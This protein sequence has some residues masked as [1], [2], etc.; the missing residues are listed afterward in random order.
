MTGIPVFVAFLVISVTGVLVVAGPQGFPMVVNSIFDT[1][2]TGALSAVPLFVLMGELLFRSGS[3]D[4]LFDS[5]DKV[6][7]RIKGRQYVLAIV[8]AAIFGA[9]SGA[10]MAVAAMMA[11]SLFPVMTSRGYDVKLSIGTIMAG[12][13]L[14]PIIPPSI[15]VIIIG[16]VA[17]VSIGG[18]LIAGVFPGLLLAAMFLGYTLVKV[19][20]SP[21]LAGEREEEAPPSSMSD[22]LFALARSMPFGVIIFSVMGFILL[23]VATPTESAATGVLGAALTAALYGRLT[24]KMISESLASAAGITAMLLAI[25]ASATI[26]SQLLAMT[27]ATGNMGQFVSS[28]GLSPWLM[29]IIMMAIPLVLCMFVDPVPLMLLLAPIYS[30]LLGP[31]GFEPIWFWCLIIINMT[32]GTITPPFGYTMFAFQGAAPGVRMSV[33]YSACWPFVAIFI[34]AMIVIALYPP[35]ATFLPSLL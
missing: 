32:V 3:V 31:L 22:K 7:G 10:A 30:P 12:A 27:G 20:L 29:L 2:N 18:L 35:I 15:L 26:F 5:V 1:T 11:R 28:L 4:V 34:L 17:N 8:L 33:I 14:A 21:V 16:T 24:W 25:M 23:G 19:R 6:I 9:V 13:C